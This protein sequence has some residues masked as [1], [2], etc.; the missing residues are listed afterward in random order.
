MAAHHSAAALG[1]YP[2]ILRLRHTAAMLNRIDELAQKQLL[3]AE[4]VGQAVLSQ[5][6]LIQPFFPNGRFIRIQQLIRQRI[7]EKIG[8]TSVPMPCTS[9]SF[10]FSESSLTYL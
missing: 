5:A 10:F 8:H 7:D 4:K 9:L 6:H 1:T 3:G 2:S